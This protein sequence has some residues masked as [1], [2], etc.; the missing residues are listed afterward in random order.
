MGIW[1]LLLKWPWLNTLFFS[2][3]IVENEGPVNPKDI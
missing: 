1:N 3:M 2:A